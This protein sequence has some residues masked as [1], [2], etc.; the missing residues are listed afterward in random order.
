M[1]RIRPGTMPVSLPG[2]ARAIKEIG[3]RKYAPNQMQVMREADRLRRKREA[4]E[5]LS[6]QEIAAWAQLAQLIMTDESLVGGLVNL[7][8]RSSRESALKDR[9]AEASATANAADASVDA[10]PLAAPVQAGSVEEFV[11]PQTAVPQAA[12]VATPSPVAG[13]VPAPAPVA[14]PAPAPAGPGDV[15]ARERAERAEEVKRFQE[16]AERRD[17]RVSDLYGLVSTAK[18]PEQ[19]R[20]VMAMV[21]GVMERDPAYAPKSLSELLFGARGGTNKVN[22]ELIDLWGKSRRSSREESLLKQMHL[23]AGIQRTQAQT[24]NVREKTTTERELRPGRV[25]KVGAQAD[26]SRASTGQRKEAAML[27]SERAKTVAARRPGQVKADEMLALAREAAAKLSDARR[28]AL[29]KK[30]AKALKRAGATIP[31]GMPAEDQTILREYAVWADTEPSKRGALGGSFG[32]LGAAEAS[33]LA[34]GVLGGMSKKSSSY[35]TL[36]KSIASIGAKA[37]KAG[38]K[39]ADKVDPLIKG[40]HAR[41]IET[42]KQLNRKFTNM[43]DEA[44]R[45]EG[46][47]ETLDPNFSSTKERLALALQDVKDLEAEM[48][49]GGKPEGE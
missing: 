29:E 17:L 48:Y 38:K 47:R 24:T 12:L 43:D 3:P 25:D 20:T 2:V 4:G 27:A 6:P 46:R 42:W 22:K 32:G 18:S 21:P 7:A 10:T 13:G 9:L 30:A 33:L 14:A 5:K 41:A 34:N 36:E 39:P 44:R 23:G 19:L 8:S 26:A 1:A 45:L 15:M 16:V 11:G 31:A 49:P 35:R 40:K 37:L 28:L